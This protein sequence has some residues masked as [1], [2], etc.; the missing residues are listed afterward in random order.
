M[1]GR[2]LL[3]LVT[4]VTVLWPLAGA[5]PADG[6]D[7]TAAIV[8]P[9]A[10]PATVGALFTMNDGRLGTHFCTASVVDSPAGDLL[11]TAAHCMAGY[12]AQ[13]PADVAFVPGYDDG[14]APYGVWP[15]TR[16]FVDAAWARSGSVNDDVAFLTVARSGRGRTIQSVTGGELVDTGQ[17]AGPVVRVTG[18][19]DT[20]NAP[21]SCV[22]RATAFGPAQLEFDCGGY[23]DG[24]SGSPFLV[25]GGP[26]GG[27]DLVMGVIGGY[28]QGGDSPVVSYS[29]VFGSNVSALYSTAVADTAVAAR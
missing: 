27:P 5:A 12:S 8:R 29:A 3:T 19:P 16:I 18:Y 1:R 17:R 22:N 23:P 6:T 10:Q 21:V 28:Q 2:I 4:V 20:G 9:G 14:A 15:V 26:A 24:T 13:A 25:A 7:L 11:I